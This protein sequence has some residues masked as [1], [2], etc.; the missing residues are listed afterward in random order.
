MRPMC[1]SDG[2][3]A[4]GLRRTIETVRLLD[5]LE[6]DLAVFGESHFAQ[7]G[8]SPNPI[9]LAAAI[10][11]H[12]ERLHLAT[13]VA[14]VPLWHPV[15]LAEDIAVADHLLQGRFEVCVGHGSAPAAYAGFDIPFD[16]RRE[17]LREILE[18]LVLAWRGDEFEH[19]GR[20][21]TVPGP[22]R[23]SPVPFRQPHPRLVLSGGSDAS[24]RAAA[25]TE[26][27]VFG[28]PSV[29]TAAHPAG[30][31]VGREIYLDERR[32]LGR[33][34]GHWR[35]AINRRLVVVDSTRPTESRP[36]D[37]NQLVG[38]PDE[39]VARVRRLRDDVDIEELNLITEFDAITPH[40]ARRSIELFGNE[41]LPRLREDE[42]AA[43]R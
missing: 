41:V 1:A 30:V 42:R 19:R 21:F 14:V 16:E 34:A 29:A 40:E 39:I 8:Q 23:V 27:E 32:R 6:F 28:T 13:G 37:A 4:T 3:H 38:T 26:F 20:H 11:Q 15:R 35:N 22:V 12:T 43:A 31:Q 24:I 2:G 5:D 10:G 36:A 33:D 7:R 9:L 25:A 18:I 17:R